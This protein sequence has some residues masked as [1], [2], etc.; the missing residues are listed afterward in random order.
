[1]SDRIALRLK[2][3]AQALGVSSRWLWQQAKEGRIP[4][5]RVQVGRKA[6]LLFP[7]EQLRDWLQREAHAEGGE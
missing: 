6:V 4:H 3:A 2:E 1:M 7:V 5:V